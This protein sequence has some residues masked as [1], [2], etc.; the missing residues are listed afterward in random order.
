MCEAEG[1]PTVSATD[2]PF[3]GKPTLLV[4]PLDKKCSYTDCCH[5]GRAAEIGTDGT[6]R[7][8]FFK[9]T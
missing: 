3:C 6:V 8:E 7:E 2:C 9:Q 4:S 5:C 1:T